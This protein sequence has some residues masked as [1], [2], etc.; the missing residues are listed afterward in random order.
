MNTAGN[1]RGFNSV[2]D[3]TA[4][5]RAGVLLLSCVFCFFV[6]CFCLFQ[7][8]AKT[9]VDT[10]VPASCRVS[11]SCVRQHTLHY[12][13]ELTDCQSQGHHTIDRLEE[14]GVESG[15]A[16]LSSLKG[17]ERAIVN[18]WNIGT[19]GKTSERRGGARMGFSERIDTILNWGCRRCARSNFHLFIVIED[20]LVA[21]LLSSSVRW[22]VRSWITYLLGLKVHG[23]TSGRRTHSLNS[24]TSVRWLVRSWITYLL[25]LKVHGITSGRMT[26]SNSFTSVRWLVRSWI[27]YLL[28]LKVHGTTSGRMTHSL[29]SF[30]SVRW[31]V[32]SWITYL[33]GL[34][35]HG[36]TSGRMTHSNSFTSVRWLVRSWIT[37]AL[38]GLKVHGITSGRM[39][40]S[41]SFTSVTLVGSFVFIGP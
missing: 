29:N 23:I 38:L 3:L 17:Q 19:V 7:F 20:W 25:G 22:L 34:K 13:A 36:I 12:T 35:V 16:R 27:T 9:C 4:G 33:L 15:S 14:R 18:Q 5:W 6:F 26:H 21:W 1:G 8:R 11:A 39:T 31:L 2:L 10:P 28:G 37:W 41:N 32:R 24:F 40:H 30:T